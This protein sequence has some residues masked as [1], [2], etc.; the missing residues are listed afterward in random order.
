MQL[1]IMDTIVSSVGRMH[2]LAQGLAR[3]DKDL[4]CQL[5]RAATSVGLNAAEGLHARGG[6]RTLRLDS[7]MCSGR[8]VM[9]AL[10]IAGAAGY[11]DPNQA[12]HE[13]SELDRIVATL[14]RLSFRRPVAS[15]E[16]G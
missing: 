9:M 10:R 13:V 7:A 5:R 6:N 3:H 8:E 1:R 15:R 11:L 2:R 12:A 4:A 14:Y 16:R